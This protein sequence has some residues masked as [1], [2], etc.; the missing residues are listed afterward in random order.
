MVLHLSWSFYRTVKTTVKQRNV[1][2]CSCTRSTRKVGCT[3]IDVGYH[4]RVSLMQGDSTCCIWTS[5]CITM[6]SPVQKYEVPKICICCILFSFCVLY[7]ALGVDILAVFYL[8]LCCFT[9]CYLAIGHLVAFWDLMVVIWCLIVN[10]VVI[11]SHYIPKTLS[12]W[13]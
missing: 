1:A 12:S 7:I 10:A 6:A 2:D 9:I 13:A 3:M 5:D 4:M 11:F 8:S